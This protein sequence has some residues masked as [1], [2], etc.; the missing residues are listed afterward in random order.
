MGM[1]SLLPVDRSAETAERRGGDWNVKRRLHSLTTTVG[2]M[3]NLTLDI[4]CVYGFL[5]D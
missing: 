4:E 1:S 3:D 2:F 5:R